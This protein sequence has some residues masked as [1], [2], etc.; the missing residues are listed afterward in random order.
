MAAG[1]HVVVRVPRNS[2]G[3]ARAFWKSGEVDKVVTLTV[4]SSQKKWVQEQKLPLQLRVRL[5]KITLDTGESEVI[6]TSLLCGKTYPVEEVAQVYR[7][8]WRIESY[9]DRLKNVW[10]IERSGKEKREHLEQDFLGVLFLST[11]ESVLSRRANHELAVQSHRRRCE[12][13][14]QVNRAVSYSALLDHTLVLL[15]DRGKSA[16][17]VLGELHQ[18]FQTNPSLERTG[19]HCPREKVSASRKLRH[20]RY[21][22]KA[23]T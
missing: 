11:L 4:T 2:F 23:L 14:K 9:I 7:W 17:Q 6:L 12:H 1:R 10:E 15:T 18:L 8:R 22:K 19:R 21:G 13:R 20:H 5:V 3:I 16:E